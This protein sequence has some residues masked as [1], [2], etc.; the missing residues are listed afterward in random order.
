MRK[1]NV[2]A[3]EEAK[4]YKLARGLNAIKESNWKKLER[5]KHGTKHF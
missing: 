5:A 3:I 1:K 2:I 4:Y